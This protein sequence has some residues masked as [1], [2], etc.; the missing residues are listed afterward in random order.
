MSDRCEVCDL[1][2]HEGERG[3]THTGGHEWGPG[4][5]HMARPPGWDK[6]IRATCTCGEPILLTGDGWEHVRPP[7]GRWRTWPISDGWVTGH[8]AEPDPEASSR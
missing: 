5:V 6:P 3:W 1:P 4:P 7:K 2:I 8:R